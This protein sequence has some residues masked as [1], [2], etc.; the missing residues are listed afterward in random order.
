MGVT[1]DRHRFEDL[2]RAHYSA[3]TRYALRRV[4][5]DAAAEIVSETFL[6]AWRRLDRVP[7]DALPWLYGIA[8]RVIANEHRRRGRA[9]RL[10]DRLAATAGPTAS[11]DHA[12]AIT[13][14]LRVHAALERLSDKDREALLLAEWEQ[15]PAADAAVV[16]G[17]S[18]ATFHVRLHR[19]RRRIAQALHLDDDH[20]LDDDPAG[21]PATPIHML[22]RGTT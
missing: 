12:E 1:D 7:E 21:R 4:G 19:A 10:V 8:R 14:R 17:C 18:T 9:A 6:T 5:A 11:G 15:L 16:L 3:V 13:D 22:T 2:F 20:D